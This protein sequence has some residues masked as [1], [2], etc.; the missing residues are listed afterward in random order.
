MKSA[1]LKV[2]PFAGA[3]TLFSCGPLV[4]TNFGPNAPLLKEKGETSLS[5]AMNLTTDEFY[6]DD[7]IGVSLTGAAAVGDH[8]A[9][10]GAFHYAGGQSE[11]D[12]T[13]HSSYW[14]LGGGW[15]KPGK[16][17]LVTEV[18]A[19]AGF[20]TIN[21]TSTGA[22]FYDVK[23]FKPFVQPSVGWRFRNIDLNV[24]SK[25]ALVNFTSE[26]KYLTDDFYPGDIENT[27]VWEPAFTF[28]VGKTV[29]FQ[30]QLSYSTFNLEYDDY[31]YSHNLFM[32]FGIIARF[33][34]KSE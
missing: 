30:Y 5:A 28:R 15:F 26:R 18:Y 32:S 27:F 8:V 9:I 16:G 34:S 23:Y 21:N 19:G 11:D 12:W 1:L 14:E 31:Y 10:A 7:L 20:G 25:F 13:R 3:I 6:D 17:K 33:G 22:E 4:Y 24:T 2:I 29:K